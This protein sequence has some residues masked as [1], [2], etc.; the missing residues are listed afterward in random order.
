MK[1]TGILR[2][3]DG[4]GRVLIPKEV[5]RNLRLKEGDLLEAYVGKEGEIIF[6]KCV[7]NNIDD[8]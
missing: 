4:I 5:R 7:P 8:D 6:K 2:R 3:I 1:T